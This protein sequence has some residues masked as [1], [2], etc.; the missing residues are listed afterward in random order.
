M[1]QFLSHCSLLLAVFAILPT[2]RR[3]ATTATI[4]LF[5]RWFSKQVNLDYF[6]LKNARLPSGLTSARSS[7]T[8]HVL[9]NV[10][11]VVAAVA[12]LTMSPY[13]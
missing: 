5:H 2:S 1:V 8:S 12:R 4:L 3:A 11:I 7:A 13:S 6:F 9:R 10:T